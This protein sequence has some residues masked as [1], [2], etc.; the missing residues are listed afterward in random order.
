VR[1]VCPPDGAP[2]LRAYTVRGWDGAARELTLD[3][4]VHGDVGL[5][6]RWAL[7]AAP[8]DRAWVV[9]PG[10]AWSPDP[11]ADHHL[12]VGDESALPAIAAAVERLPAGARARVLIEVPGPADEL[13][14][15][16]P[17]G[18]DVEITWLHR[19]GRVVGSAL[20]EAIREL[21]WLPGRT[22]A[23][24]HGE[25]GFVADLRRYLRIERRMPREDLSVS[26][27]WRLGADDEGWRAAKKGWAAELDT[28]EKGA[29]LT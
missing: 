26:G 18:A 24:V 1:S 8:G 11:R 13:A 9:G 12:L 20:V 15:A 7:R 5:G 17:A 2:R 23:F 14:L 16:P 10:G 28:A 22:A 25:A 4:V 21:D 27:Y 6:G 19:E 3:I 29:G